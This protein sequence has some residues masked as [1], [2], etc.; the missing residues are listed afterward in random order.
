MLKVDNTSLSP[1]KNC[2]AKYYW[3]HERG[4]V[5]LE[6]DTL[7]M[8][9]GI[10]IHEALTHDN[11]DAAQAAFIHTYKECDPPIGKIDEGLRGGL[12]FDSK[13]C[14]LAGMMLLEAYFEWYANQPFDVIEQE[15]GFS[16]QLAPAEHGF[17]AIIYEGRIDKIVRWRTDE[18][19]RIMDHKTS[20][21]PLEKLCFN[22]S[23]QMTGYVVGQRIHGIE[24][25]SEII[26]DHMLVSA[27]PRDLKAKS[28]DAPRAFSRLITPRSEIVLDRWIADTIHWCR[29]I[30]M[31]Q[32]IG[33][34]PQNADHYCTAYYKQCEYNALC[35]VDDPESLVQSR[36]KVDRWE[37]WKDDGG[38][39][40][41]E[42]DA[43]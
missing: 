40:E 34:W 26:I 25:V 19:L 4:L 29:E 37:P 28:G 20:S 24:Q 2:K 15:I 23:G 39:D 35:T 6:Q 13:H 18:M 12:S 30:Q 41:T 8:D 10:A 9:F 5:P 33:K 1:A 38:E 42:K 14:V 7:A 11:L 27:Y 3:R 21:F 36:Y 16:F 22:P 31:C 43:R 32:R 17:D